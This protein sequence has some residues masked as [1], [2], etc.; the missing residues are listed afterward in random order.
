V[1]LTMLF[2]QLLTEEQSA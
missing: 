1:K 2:Q